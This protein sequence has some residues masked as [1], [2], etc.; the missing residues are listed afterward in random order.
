MTGRIFLKLIVGVFCL[1][2][3]A[4]VTV[5]YSASEVARDTNIQNLIQQLA[6]KGR[7]LAVSVT[8]P[9]ALGVEQARKMAAA[10][11]GRLTLVRSD[12]KVMVDSEADAA[13]M[14]NHRTSDRSELIQA[15]GGEVT[16]RRSPPESLVTSASPGGQRSAS[17]AISTVRLISQPLTASIFS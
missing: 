5:D 13:G 7:M 4:L 16:R 9:A 12:G 11:G 17:M 8:D 10:A 15:F 6:E 1:L 2:L 14:E 3:L